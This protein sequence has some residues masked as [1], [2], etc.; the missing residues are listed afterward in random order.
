ML[1][2]AYSVVRNNV[3]TSTAITVIQVAVPAT[4][5]IEITRAWAT[6][7]SGTTSAANRIQIVRK[8]GAATVTS[9]TPTPLGTN[10][11]ASLCVGGT[12]LTGITATGEGTDGNV[13][14]DEGF[15]VLNGW[16][17]VPVLEERII[18]RPSEI[19]GLKFPAAPTNLTWNC[20][21]SWL[22]Y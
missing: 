21:I 9:A 5:L 20:G 8:T 16:L 11:G 18:V 10:Y 17:Y 15:N 14:V 13:L 6:Q 22:E 12:S 7:S 1:G 4:T 19:I 3:A 2:R